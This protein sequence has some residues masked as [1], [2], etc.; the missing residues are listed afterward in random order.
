[1]INL[2]DWAKKEIEI[3]CKKEAPDRKEGEWDY[4]CACYDSALKAFESLLEDGHSGFSI[5]IT[6]NILIRLIDGKPLTPIED[7]EDVW[8]KKSWTR[9]DGT[10]VY[11]C[12]RMSS[13]FKDVYPDGTV[14]YNDNERVICKDINSGVCYHNGFLKNIVREMFPITMPYMPTDKQYVLVT[15][16]FLYDEKNGDFDTIGVFYVTTPD[17][18]RIDINRYF[19]ESEDGFVEIDEIEYGIRK[20]EGK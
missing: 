10:E 8:D 19:K 1:M 3:A 14:K 5:G 15:E 11:Q 4:G 9:D 20:G 12:K 13:L 7:T 6:K 16:D 17:G 18:N 2:L